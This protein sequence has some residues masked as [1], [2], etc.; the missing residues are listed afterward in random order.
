VYTLFQPCRDRA[1][2]RRAICPARSHRC[3]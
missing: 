2:P 1:S 3:P